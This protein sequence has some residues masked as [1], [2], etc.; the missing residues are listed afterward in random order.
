MGK[1]IKCAVC[2]KDVEAKKQGRKKYC[3][4]CATSVY[5]M[6][7]NYHGKFTGQRGS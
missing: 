1:I 4:D 5:V 7:S 2:G 6:G 3:E